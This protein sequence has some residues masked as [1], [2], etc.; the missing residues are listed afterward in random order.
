M[1]KFFP[2]PSLTV[3]RKMLQNIPMDAGVTE[4]TKRRLAE[5]IQGCKTEKE[6]FT[7]VIWICPG[8]GL[9]YDKAT[10][11][12]VGFE[13]WG[14]V[15]TEKYVDHALVFRMRM[16]GSGD[17]F[18]LTFNFCSRQTTTSQLITGMKDV[19]RAIKEAGFT[20]V[21]TVCDCGSSNQAA[22]KTLF[23]DAIRLKGE[24]YVYRRILPPRLPF[25]F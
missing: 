3:L 16:I 4:E 14:N 7:F 2:L 23:Q 22:I 18:P 5:A 25:N 13:E 17:K 9:F 1:R 10:D 21:A 15:R 6:K 11:K 8:C 19:V 20:V 24:D 12:V